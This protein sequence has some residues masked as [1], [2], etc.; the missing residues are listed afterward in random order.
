MAL[1]KR[2]SMLLFKILQTFLLGAL[3]GSLLQMRHDALVWWVGMA[4]GSVLSFVVIL[5]IWPPYPNEEKK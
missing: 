3:W 4:I 2:N 5:M 1:S